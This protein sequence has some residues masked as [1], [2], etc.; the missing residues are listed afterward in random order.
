MSA[1]DNMAGTSKAVMSIEEEARA[2]NAG[3]WEVH[4]RREEEEELDLAAEEVGA[5]WRMTEAGEEGYEPTTTDGGDHTGG[6]STEFAARTEDDSSGNPTAKKKKKKPRKDRKPTALASTTTEITQVSESGLPLE[7]VDVPAG[8]GMQLGCIFRE[9]MS[10]NMK[11]LRGEGNENLVD[12]CL[13]MLHQW[14]T[15]PVPYNT[16]STSNK[17]DRLAITKMSSHTIPCEHPTR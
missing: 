1:N 14:Y 8:Y 2:A 9:S 12:L 3:F 17:V 11:K 13:W 5:D 10:I 7:P 16:L 4:S 15:F 6:D